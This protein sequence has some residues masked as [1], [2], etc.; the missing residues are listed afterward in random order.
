[1]SILVKFWSK[2][3]KIWIFFD[4]SKNFDLV[5]FS[6]NFELGKNFQK[7]SIFSKISKNFDFFE[8][9]EKFR[10]ILGQ[11]FEKFRVW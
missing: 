6:K 8:H 9:F 1:M 10:L 2:F 5:K 11:I 7:I 4:T 3:A